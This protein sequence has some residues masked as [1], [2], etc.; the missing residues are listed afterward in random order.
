MWRALTLFDRCL[1][2]LKYRPKPDLI[3]STTIID[4]GNIIIDYCNTILQQKDC[5]AC[6]LHLTVHSRDWI[7]A[8]NTSQYCTS[9]K[10]IYVSLKHL[11]KQSTSLHTYSTQ[12]QANTTMEY[13]QHWLYVR[14]HNVHAKHFNEVYTQLLIHAYEHNMY[15]INTLSF[16]TPPHNDNDQSSEPIYEQT[17]AHAQRLRRPWQFL[18][19]Q[20]T[21]SLAV[22]HCGK[23]RFGKEK[24]NSAQKKNNRTVVH[25]LHNG[26]YNN[27]NL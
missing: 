23:G 18:L 21:L 22:V 1:V 9:E 17:P 20:W 11:S 3:E 19:D 16:V 25:S 24:I 2:W 4:N 8:R 5:S 12:F 26:T 27:A 10:N 13:M 7:K 14:V 6:E 15:A